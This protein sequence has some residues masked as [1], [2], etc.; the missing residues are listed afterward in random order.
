MGNNILIVNTHMKTFA[1]AVLAAVAS[2]AASDHWAVIMAGSKTYSNYR[3]QADSHHAVKIMLANGI[4]RENIIHLAYDDIANNRENPFKGQLFNKPDVSGPGVNVY[5]A[6]EIDYSGK[7][8]N[9]ENFFKVLLGD[10]S[11]PGPVL[12]SNSESKVFIYFVDHGGRGL[13]CTPSSFSRDWIYAD[14]L[15]STLQQMK[16]NGMFKELTFYLETCESGSMFP[17]LTESENIYAMTASNA[18]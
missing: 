9:K 10:T 13:I 16:D 6:T 2:A 12:K 5:D 4:P 1:C 14:D 11:A 18:T 7:E 8:V 3:H 15:D 17:N